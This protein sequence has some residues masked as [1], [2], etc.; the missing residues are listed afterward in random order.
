MKGEQPQGPAVLLPAALLSAWLWPLAFAGAQPRP[1]VETAEATLPPVSVNAPAGIDAA[2]ELPVALDVVGAARIRDAG[3]GASLA[4]SLATV[5]GVVARER[6]NPA[7]DVQISMRG[8]GARASFGI[9]GLRLYVDDIPATLPDGQGQLSHVDPSL[10]DRIEILR[11]PFSSLY[12]NAAGGVLRLFTPDGSGPPT[13]DGEL[14]A[15]SRGWVRHRFGASGSGEGYGYSAQLARQRTDGWR[16]HSAAR[17]DVANLKLRLVPDEAQTLTLT[18]NQLRQPLAQDPLGLTRAQF[19]AD[20]RQTDAAA[21]S[22]DTRKTL[23][24]LQAGGVYERR[25]RAG[26]SLRLMVYAGRREAEQFQAIPLAVQRNPLHAGGVIDLRREYAGADLRWRV[27]T[28][29][30]GAPLQIT[31]GLAYD[32]LAEDRRGY[33]NFVGG[34][35]GVRGA[36]RRDERNRV[37]NLDP[38]LQW[39][40]RPAPRWT[41]QAGLRQ[42]RVRFESDDRYQLGPNGDDSGGARYRASLPMAGLQYQPSA[43]WQFYLS[44]GRGFETPTFNELSYR[45]DGG[46]GLNFELRPAVSRS[47]EAGLR[48]QPEGGAQLHL[49]VFRTETDD[50]IAVAGSSGGRTTFR[51]AGGSRRDGAELSFGAPLGRHLR[52]QLALSWIDARYRTA[53]ADAGTSAAALSAGRRIP[54]I[55]AALAF[56]ELAWRPPQGW[57][58]AVDL[59]AAGR[60]WAD[61]RNSQAAPGHAVAGLGVGYRLRAGDWRFDAFGRVDNLFDRRYA[62]SLIVNETNGRFY[63]PGA[64]RQ[65]SLGARLQRQF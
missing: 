58:A 50:E 21:L 52:W 2:N 54:G 51:N 22:F 60:A 45:P 39:V 17:R 7:Q 28:E 1:D 11:G 35:L 27:D 63:E 34:T 12:G 37:A 23:M 56:A 53:G 13:L 25:L 42:T 9:R 3:P 20:P 41:V 48:W 15:G 32:A 8:F 31:A 4:E 55:P 40:W 62:G 24:Q 26:Q 43:R 6:L 30:A 44:A 64:G 38:Y 33:E 29:L 5:P 36:L 10:L 49:A 47:I 65:W 59:R 16:P 57:Q 18:V 19:D 46:A 14:A 61:D